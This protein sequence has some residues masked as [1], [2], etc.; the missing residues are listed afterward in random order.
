M[1][2]VVIMLAHQAGLLM[3]TIT[4]AQAAMIIGIAVKNSFYTSIVFS[5]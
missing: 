2:M 1:A 3:N 4:M 5:F